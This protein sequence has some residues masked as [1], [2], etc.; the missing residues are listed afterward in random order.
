MANLQDCCGVI[1]VVPGDTP[2]TVVRTIKSGNNFRVKMAIIVD[3]Q[4]KKMN[5]KCTVCS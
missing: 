3:S 1:L 5:N 4:M 2:C